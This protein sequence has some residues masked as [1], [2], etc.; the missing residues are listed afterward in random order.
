[1]RYTVVWKPQAK[2]DL[3]ELWLASGR[4]PAVTDAANY[5]DMAL[6][7]R[8][9]LIGAVRFDTVRI[10]K[11]APVVVE[12]EVVEDDRMVWVLAVWLEE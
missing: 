6:A 10:V 7:R 9:E 3:A 2:K 12:Y 11:A 1:M 5:L 8:P 4:S